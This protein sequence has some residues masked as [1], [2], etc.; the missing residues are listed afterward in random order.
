MVKSLEINIVGREKRKTEV[1]KL[2]VIQIG[3]PSHQLLNYLCFL[4]ASG[5]LRTIL[6]K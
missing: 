4:H 3:V 1:R 5:I 2:A 6:G